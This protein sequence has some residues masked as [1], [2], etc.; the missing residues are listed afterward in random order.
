MR[1]EFDFTTPRSLLHGHVT[2][3]RQE[4]RLNVSLDQA[5]C[6]HAKALTY[7]YG[8][9]APY[10]ARVRG[11][12]CSARGDREGHVV[13]EKVASIAERLLTT[14]RVDPRG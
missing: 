6:I 3:L 14:E 11:R 8:R 10:R 2:V 1:T 5:I 13:W 7:Q 9:A 4:A 12:N